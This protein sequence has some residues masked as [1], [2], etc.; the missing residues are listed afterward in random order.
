[1]S[2]LDIKL[3]R[4]FRPMPRIAPVRFPQRL[5][6]LARQFRLLNIMRERDLLAMAQCLKQIKFINQTAANRQFR[7]IEPWRLPRRT[8]PQQACWE[9]LQRIMKD[10]RVTDKVKM[11]C[12]KRCPPEA[13]P[14]SWRAK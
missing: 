5:G 14:S 9:L 3:V 4:Q 8:S 11:D 2:S 10:P 1:M 6:C 12:W 13:F 7:T